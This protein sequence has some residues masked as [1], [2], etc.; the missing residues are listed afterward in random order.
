MI[1]E[2]YAPDDDAQIVR[3]IDQALDNR[4]ESSSNQEDEDIGMMPRTGLKQQLGEDD[5]QEELVSVPDDLEQRIIKNIIIQ[6]AKNAPEQAILSRIPYQ[7]GQVFSQ[8][9]T[10]KLIRNVYDLGFFRNVRVCVEPVGT[11]ELNLVVQVEEKRLLEGVEFRGNRHL[12]MSEIE[13]KIDFSKILTIDQD[14]LPYYIG[15]IKR[16]YREKDYHEAQIDAVIED[17][18]DHAKVIFI[19]QEGSMTL[20]KRVC[21][22]GNKHFTSKKLRSLLFTREDWIL[23]FLD[24]AGSYQP[25][26]IQADKQ[27]IENFYQSNG[28]INARVTS[29]ACELDPIYKGM[30]V[31]FHVQEGDQYTICDIR[32]PG[33]DIISEEE[34]VARLPIKVGD[35]YS[36]EKIRQTIEAL[37]VFWG[38]RGYINADIEPSIQPDDVNKTVSIAFYTE[39]GSPVYLNRLNIFGNKKTH[40]K[41]IRRQ[42]L[43]EEGCLLTTQAM[44]DSKGRVE[45]LG[46]FDARNGVNWRVHRLSD[47]RVDLDLLVREVKTGRFEFQ[48]SFG[49]WAR[50]VSSPSESFTVAVNARETNLFGRG[51]QLVGSAALSKEERDLNFN[52]TN[53]WLFDRPI[54]ASTDLYFKRSLYDEFKLIE[55]SDITERITGGSITVGALSSKLYNSTVAGKIG[56]EAITYGETPRVRSAALTPAEAREL[57]GIFDRRFASGA[58][59]LFGLTAFKDVRNHPLHPSRGYQYAAIFRTGFH[60]TLKDN[61]KDN[62][63]EIFEIDKQRTR[64]GYS[65]IDLDASWYTPLIGERDLILGLHGHLGLV[66]AFKNRSIPFRE[67]YHIG[68]PASVRGF[69]YGE[70]GP[71]YVATSLNQKDMIGAKKAFWLNA[72]V[73]YPITSDFGMKGAVFYDGGAGWDT[74]DSNLINPARLINNSFSFR[75][76]VGIG[77]RILQPTPVKIDWGFKLDRKKGETASEVHFSMYHEF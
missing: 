20:I 19:I 35:L 43:L 57:Q 77:V 55:Q 50:D 59:L 6:G 66:A 51:I 2:M 15:I 68:G 22:I 5:D 54:H 40:D 60:S 38:S 72:E 27:V 12:S 73:I 13:K 21:F 41:V 71:M 67:L 46:Y 26:A 34:L 49:G 70:I 62:P 8:R 11:D 45:G 36:R 37:R 74:P 58:F 10:N 52:L 17:R 18:D 42:I 53:P 4:S 76:S 7:V 65:K 64:F 47:D 28:F 32:A 23:G 69:L 24:R 33:N 63:A 25:E 56:A 1:Q 39:L 16:L 48:M 30:L 44:D 31:T 61:P 14:D 75:H 3:E 9:K 29:V